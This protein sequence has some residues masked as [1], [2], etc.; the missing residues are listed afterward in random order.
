MKKR[1]NPTGKEETKVDRYTVT[2]VGTLIEELHGRIGQI[3]EGH[4]GIVQRLEKLETASQNVDKGLEKV[5]IALHG[6]SRRLDQ[7]E[8]GLDVVNGKVERLEDAVSKLSADLKETRQEL[9]TEIH[10]LGNRL[11]IVESRR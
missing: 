10:Q 9:K 4:V 1:T 2:E 3:A 8:L 5:E 6:N 11:A 7:V